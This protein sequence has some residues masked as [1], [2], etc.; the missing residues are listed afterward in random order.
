ME[1]ELVGRVHT[2]M[3]ANRAPRGFG[4]SSCILADHESCADD[5]DNIQVAL[6]GLIRLRSWCFN[7]PSCSACLLDVE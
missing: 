7:D 2:L 5:A 1:L 4:F 6:P 3:T